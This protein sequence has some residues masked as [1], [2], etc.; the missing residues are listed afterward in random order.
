M[1]SKILEIFDSLVHN[2]IRLSSFTTVGILL[3]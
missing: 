1:G 2:S 3:N